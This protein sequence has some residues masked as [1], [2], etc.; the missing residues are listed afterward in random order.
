MK[1]ITKNNENACDLLLFLNLKLVGPFEF[2]NGD[3]NKLRDKQILIHYRFYFDL[4]EFQTIIIDTSTS[5]QLITNK[6]KNKNNGSSEM[7]QDIHYGFWRD[8]PKYNPVGIVQSDGSTE[9]SSKSKKCVVPIAANLFHFI[10][11]KLKENMNK[12]QS[13]NMLKLLN[14]FIIK[15]KINADENGKLLP[16]K[17]RQSKIVAKTFHEFGLIVPMNGNIGYRPIAYNLNELKKIFKRMYDKKCKNKKVD[18]T[19]VEYLLGN[20]CLADDEG[21]PG[22]GYELGIDFFY[23]Y[24]MFENHSKRLLLNAY[25]LTQRDQFKIILNAHLEVRQKQN[26][27]YNQ[28]IVGDGEEMKDEEEGGNNGNTDNREK[29]KKKKKNTRKKKN[30][31]DNKQKKMTAFF[32]QNNKEKKEEKKKIVKNS[33]DELSSDSD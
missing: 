30:K 29:K 15:N 11:D 26:G 17:E 16:F 10:R 9:V 7:A 23:S 31:K 4:P 8:D 12:S 20:I 25:D 33:L 24:K 21:D 13:K 22:M 1:S 3:L 28:L 32:K 14:E 27:K 5:T 18:G 6:N 19:E 2:L